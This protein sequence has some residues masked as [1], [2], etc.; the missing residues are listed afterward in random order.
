MSKAI[1]TALIG[2]AHI[3]TPNFVKRMNER[4]DVEVAGVWDHDEKRAKANADALSSPVVADLEA[5]WNDPAIDAVVICS[6]TDRHLELVLAAA[7]AGKPMFVEK[8]LGFS[9]GDAKL[10]ADAISKAGV[11][12][13]TGYFMRGN[14][15]FRFVKSSIEAGHFGRVT[16]VRHQNCHSGSLGG[17][18][19]TDWRWMADPAVAGCGAFG[20]LGTHSLDLL[21]HLMGRPMLVTADLTV[22]TGRYGNEC[23]ETGEGYLRFADGVLGSIAGAWVDVAN[24]VTLEV[25]GTEG[26]AVIFNGELYFKSNKVEGA[27]GKTPWTKLGPELKH[28][29]ELFFDAL[30]GEKTPLVT[31]EEAADRNAVME[32]LYRGAKEQRWVAPV[33]HH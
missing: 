27:D 4:T 23:E 20:D 33:Y 24:P 15:L 13:Q 14:P 10:M 28:A 12:F 3:H 8:P 22:V 17:W 5:I 9:G 11:L 7:R 16:R 2:C 26:H 25:S 6:E 21:M 29:F 19:D 1:R 30:A 18:F 31:V 32:A